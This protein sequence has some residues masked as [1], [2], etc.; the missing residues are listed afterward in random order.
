MYSFV[1]PLNRQRKDRLIGCIKNIKHVFGQ[2]I[3]DYEIIVVEQQDEPFKLGQLRNVGF[4]L[5]NFGI[6]IF[7]D[8]DMRFC[9]P[10]I[11]FK[12]LLNKYKAP[13][14]CWQYISQVDEDEKYKLTERTGEWLQKGKGWGGV[15]AFTTKQ[16]LDCS[17]YS[18]LLAGWGKEDDLIAYRSGMRRLKDQEILHVYH[19]RKKERN[20]YLKHNTKI[21]ELTKQN[22]IFH[23]LDGWQQT[24]AD[25]SE[26]YVYKN[27]RKY[28]VSNIRVDKDKYIKLYNEMLKIA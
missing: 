10:Y 18:N 4:S 15:N 1:I 11:H 3:N 16:F 17:G 14:V 13:L 21:L 2:Y 24:I 23:Y 28:Q 8:V 19:E 5:C 12:H 27:I 7:V 26:L 22:Q 20:R 9:G 25:I 6:T